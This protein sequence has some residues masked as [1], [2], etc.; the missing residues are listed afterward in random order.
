MIFPEAKK[1]SF[2]MVK[3]EILRFKE[4]LNTIIEEQKEKLE[5]IANQ[6]S[7]QISDYMKKL[8]E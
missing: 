3:S 8:E 4:T 1:E 2:A 6:I 7:N 5:K